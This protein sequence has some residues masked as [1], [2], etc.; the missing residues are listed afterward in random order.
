MWNM[1]DVLSLES[2]WFLPLTWFMFDAKSEPASFGVE[3]K[4]KVNIKVHDW[5]PLCPYSTT[6][7]TKSSPYEG[8]L[9]W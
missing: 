6:G 5:A 3:R 9:M 4:G 8:Y 2:Q 7:P 1:S